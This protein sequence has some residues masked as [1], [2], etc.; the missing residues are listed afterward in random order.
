MFAYFCVKITASQNLLR[1]SVAGRR[2]ASDFLNQRA[3]ELFFSRACAFE[4]DPFSSR[5]PIGSA[6]DLRV[7]GDVGVDAINGLHFNCQRVS[8][9]VPTATIG[10]RYFGV[11]AQL[12]LSDNST[13]RKSERLADDDSF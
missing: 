2:R 9:A 1:R 11:V 4:R 6:F 8:P 12:G 3:Q 13:F 10:V 5:C 7:D